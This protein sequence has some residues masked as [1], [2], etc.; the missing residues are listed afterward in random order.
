M[1]F[2]KFWKSNLNRLAISGSGSNGSDGVELCRE[3]YIPSPSLF[4]SSST[5][6][7]FLLIGSKSSEYLSSN[8]ASDIMLTKIKINF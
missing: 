5:G 7:D 3:N 4:Y 8:A 6:W 1:I 2:C